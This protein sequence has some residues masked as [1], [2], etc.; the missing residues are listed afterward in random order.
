M[1]PADSGKPRAPKGP[2]K[3]F[4]PLM[5]KSYLKAAEAA[6]FYIEGFSQRPDREELEWNSSGWKEHR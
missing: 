6:L 5:I 3:A 1:L 2:H 4:G